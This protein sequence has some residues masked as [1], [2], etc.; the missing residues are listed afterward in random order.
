M[1]NSTGAE[2]GERSNVE[3]V[4]QGYVVAAVISTSGLDVLLMV[5]LFFLGFATLRGVLGCALSLSD[6]VIE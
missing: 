4:M 2:R 5:T 3:L 1:R 6:R